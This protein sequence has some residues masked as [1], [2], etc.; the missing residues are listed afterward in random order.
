LQVALNFAGNIVA[1]QQLRVGK[2][3]IRQFCGHGGGR[4]DWQQTFTYLGLWA[5]PFSNVIGHA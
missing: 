2:L 1:R 3:G 5:L 4:T